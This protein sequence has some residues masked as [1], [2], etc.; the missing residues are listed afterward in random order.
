MLALLA[1]GLAVAG[2]NGKSSASRARERAVSGSVTFDGI[3]TAGEATAFRKVISAFNKTYPNV[4]INYKPVGNNVPTVLATAVAGGR[5]PDMADIA[6]PGYIKQLAQ[7]G[8]L[9][10]DHLREVDDGCQLRA[11]LA[12]PRDVR[13]QALRAPLQGVQQVALLVQRARRLRLQA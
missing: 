1:A 12:R 5:P 4:H 8:H 13:R 7:Q 3:W 9:E 10:A 6:Q 11:V 2:T